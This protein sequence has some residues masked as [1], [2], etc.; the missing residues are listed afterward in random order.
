MLLVPP[1]RLETIVVKGAV[2]ES[3][4][5]EESQGRRVDMPRFVAVPSTTGPGVAKETYL[6]S[7]P[8]AEP[9]LGRRQ[10]V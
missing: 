10:A 8:S 1:L 5:Q 3:R 6:H 4:G 2:N 7:T 9:P